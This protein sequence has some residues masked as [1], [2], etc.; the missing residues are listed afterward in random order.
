MHIFICI[1]KIPKPKL[2]AFIYLKFKLCL[3]YLLKKFNQFNS[4]FFIITLN[5]HVPV[6]LFLTSSFELCLKPLQNSRQCSYVTVVWTT[7]YVHSTGITNKSCNSA[8]IQLIHINLSLGVAL[9]ICT[10]N[11]VRI[12]VTCKSIG[13]SNIPRRILQ[14]L[15]TYFLGVVERCTPKHTIMKGN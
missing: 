2:N 9:T 12:S 11:S 1:I 15:N 10:L 14:L 8:R 5:W 6:L 7:V 4:S 3:P 13:M